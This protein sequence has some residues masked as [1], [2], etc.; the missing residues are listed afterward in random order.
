MNSWIRKAVIPTAILVAA[1]FTAM[2]V[3]VPPAAHAQASDNDGC[4]LATLNGDY[5][6]RISG[7]V[8]NSNGSI[9]QRDGIVMQHFDGA[10]G[11]TQQDF[12]LGNG[13]PV[14]GPVD[15]STL[16]HTGE[17][18]S[19][20]INPDCTGNATVNFPA[21]PGETGA[22][23]QVLFVLSNHGRTI[24]QIVTGLF[25][26]TPTDITAVAL[27]ANIHADGEK[28]GSVRGDSEDNGHN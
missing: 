27:P 10:G 19:Y 5:A 3:S 14:P 11:I 18:G 6:I 16:F 1:I 24:H 4:S 7:Q 28:L 22:K 8:F 9:T 2:T 13:V 26:P 23:I 25:P 17:G 21:P 15:P 12:V 20:V